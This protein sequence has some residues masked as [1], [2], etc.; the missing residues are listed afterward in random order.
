MR[1][2]PNHPA[3][4]LLTEIGTCCFALRENEI[5]PSDI[6]ALHE[7]LDLLLYHITPKPGW[8]TSALKKAVGGKCS[9]DGC[10]E[11]KKCYLVGNQWFCDKHV[12][13]TI[14]FPIGMP[15]SDYEAAGRQVPKQGR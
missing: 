2:H 8:I 1:L 11:T 14:T 3:S 4:E 6:S 15:D 5:T 9:V 12:P 7:R 13:P 10:N